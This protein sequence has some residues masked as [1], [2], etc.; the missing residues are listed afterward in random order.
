M[1]NRVGTV[2]SILLFFFLCAVCDFIW[3]YAHGGS[4]PASVISVVGGLF[5]TAFYLL[6]FWP[7]KDGYEP[8][9]P[10]PPTNHSLNPK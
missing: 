10:H 7:R 1:T 5:G 9:P 3:G 8:Q 2:R 6:L 4:F